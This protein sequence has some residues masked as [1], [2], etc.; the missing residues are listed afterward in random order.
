VVAS[1]TWRP[2]GDHCRLTVHGILHAPMGL[3]L[4]SAFLSKNSTSPG[5]LPKPHRHRKRLNGFHRTYERTHNPVH[6]SRADGAWG[7][8]LQHALADEGVREQG[9]A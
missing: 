2:H 1:S 7:V 8:R 4:P 9:A 5:R 3:H 6:A